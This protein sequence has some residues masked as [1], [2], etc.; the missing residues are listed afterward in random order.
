[1]TS[2][3]FLSRRPSSLNC[4]EGMKGMVVA[5][6]GNAKCLQSLEGRQRRVALK[7]ALI[8][9]ILYML[10]GFFDRWLLQLATFYDLG[11]IVVCTMECAMQ[12]ELDYIFWSSFNKEAKKDNRKETVAKTTY[13]RKRDRLEAPLALLQGILWKAAHMKMVSYLPK[14]WA[15]ILICCWSFSQLQ[16]RFGYKIAGLLTSVM[17]FYSMQNSF[18]WHINAIT[19]IWTF[20]LFVRMFLSPYF[21]EVKFNTGQQELWFR[22]RIGILQGF[23]LVTYICIIRYPWLSAF[24]FYISHSSAAILINNV[25]DPRPANASRSS[26]EMSRWISRQVLWVR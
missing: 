9:G 26:K 19:H 23:G 24:I 7:L 15:M 1:M 3:I 2:P 8:S 20:E 14:K 5:L 4:N 18:T 16:R 22:S 12:S 10:L 21:K 13:R 6:Q 17:C 25:T 11:M